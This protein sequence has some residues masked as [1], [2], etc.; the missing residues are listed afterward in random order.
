MPLD[1][2]PTAAFGLLLGILGH[3]VGWPIAKG[4]SQKVSD[5]L[6]SYLTSLGGRIVTF[7]HVKSLRELPSSHVTLLNVT[8]RQV[9]KLAGDRLPNG[10][11]YELEKFRHGPGVF[12][13]DWALNSPI[14]WKARQCS[15]AGTLHLGG[16]MEEIVASEQAVARGRPPERPLV[17]LAQQSLFDATRAPA[18]RHTAWAYCHVP[19]GSKLDMT[20]RI[21]GQ[22]ERFAPGFR[23]CISERNVMTTADF[24]TYNPNYIGGD[25]SGGLQNP[26]QIVARPA[27]RLNPYATPVPGLYI[28]SSSTPPGGGVHGM[29]GYYAARAALAAVL[30]N[31]RQVRGRG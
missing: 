28:C 17:I 1:A 23:D 2:S 6:G 18:G 5:A 3:A 15:R 13:L 14:P 21:E 31:Q 9:I 8:P 11:R 27:F 4:G 26:W 20:E 24:E 7:R 16:T 30:Y 19:N 22:I 29:C 25:I 10:Y 12:K